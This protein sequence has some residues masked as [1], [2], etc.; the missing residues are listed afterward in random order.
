MVLFSTYIA[1]YI[2]FLGC[3]FFEKDKIQIYFSGAMVLSL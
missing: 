2:P 3:V 1:F